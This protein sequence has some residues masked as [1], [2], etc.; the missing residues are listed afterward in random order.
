MKFSAALLSL[1]LIAGVGLVAPEARADDEKAK[2][3]EILKDT[4]KKLQKG[5]KEFTKGLGVKCNACHVKGKFDSD[6]LKPK[7]AG[8]DFFKVTV[9]NKDAAK[10]DAAL[11]ALLKALELDAAKDGAKVWSGVDMLE[12]K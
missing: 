4:G 2:N 3:L 12:K 9:G 6:E 1:T 10:R 5:M 8:R 11:K 7:V